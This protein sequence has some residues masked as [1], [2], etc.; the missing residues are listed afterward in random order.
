MRIAALNEEA[1]R[2]MAVRQRHSTHVDTLLSQPASKRLSR[3]LT[4]AIGIGV[5]G[6][7][8]GSWTVAELAELARMEMGA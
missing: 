4:T 8:D 5:K 2:I 6:Q 3:L 7:V 1:I